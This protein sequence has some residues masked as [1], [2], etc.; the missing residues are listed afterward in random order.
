MLSPKYLDYLLEYYNIE[1]YLIRHGQSEN[2]HISKLAKNGNLIQ[3]FRHRNF[4]KNKK[5]KDCHL[6]DQGIFESIQLGNNLYL[7]NI[8]FDHIFCSPLNRCIET[9]YYSIKNHENYKKVIIN[10]YL[11]EVIS[12][13]GDYPNNLLDKKNDTKKKFSCINFSFFDSLQRN[14]DGSFVEEIN[15]FKK[16]DKNL[17]VKE[18]LQVKEN[19]YIFWYYLITK[20]YEIYFKEKNTEVNQKKKKTI[21]IGIYSHCGFI[22]LFE[23]EVIKYYFSNNCGIKTFLNKIKNLKNTDVAK[24]TFSKNNENKFNMYKKN[25]IYNRNYKLKINLLDFQYY[26]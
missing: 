5:Y 14:P 18:H 3:R 1:I 15:E 13:I 6:T 8:K 12:S 21:K 20:L 10:E 24:L 9:C 22:G 17:Y 25:S 26:Y 2:N 19:A 23:R 4:Y 16:G 11:R 7:N